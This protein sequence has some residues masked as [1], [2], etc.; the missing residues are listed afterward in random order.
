MKDM[1]KKERKKLTERISNLES[2][3][4][5]PIGVDLWICRSG[6]SPSIQISN[7][8]L[9]AQDFGLN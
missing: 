3:I 4:L 1:R 7:L 5:G 9:V 8:V 6:Y 2:V